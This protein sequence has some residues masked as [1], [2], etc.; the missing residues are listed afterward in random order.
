[1][2]LVVGHQILMDDVLDV[3]VY[4]VDS[5]VASADGQEHGD[6]VDALAECVH[7]D[8]E[9]DVQEPLGCRPHVNVAFEGR[10]VAGHMV[11]AHDAIGEVVAGVQHAKKFLRLA[12]HQA[13]LVAVKDQVGQAVMGALGI[14]GEIVAPQLL[15]D[16]Q[17]QV[18]V[19]LVLV[20]FEGNGNDRR[21][22]V[23]V[24]AVQHQPHRGFQVQE[25][26]QVPA[27]AV[28]DVLDF[29]V[30]RNEVVRALIQPT[31]TLIADMPLRRFRHC[32]V[33]LI[34]REL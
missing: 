16:D 3:V 18:L 2:G 27:D 23:D 14:P 25:V 32:R 7:A 9:V 21:D 28:H 1:M 33:L 34:S 17:A 11:S 19:N 12:A 10:H 29:L 20:S 31:G 4:A 15:K 13:G 26:L 30:T 5:L 8:A 24:V 22:G 6:P